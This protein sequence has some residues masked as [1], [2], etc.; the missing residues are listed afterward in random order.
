MPS[1]KTTNLATKGSEITV[2]LPVRNG[3]DYVA[4][5]IRSVLAQSFKDFELWILENGSDDGTAEV[6]RTFAD[7]RITLFELG[8]VGVQGALQ[9]AIE[10]AQTLWLA[11]M[12][13]DDLMFPHR[14]ERQIQ[15]LRRNPATVFLGTAYAFLTPFGHIVEIPAREAREV[16]KE[17]VAGRRGFPDSSLVFNRLAALDAGGVD[18]DFMKCDGLP[19]MFRLLTQGKAWAV[20][21]HLQ[22]YR[23][24]PDS[25]SKEQEHDEESRQIHFKYAPEFFEPRPEP[26]PR[27]FWKMVARLEMLSG[28]LRCVQ[29]AL[30]RMKEEGN[31][32]AEANEFPFNNAFGALGRAY[33]KWRYSGGYRRRPDWEKLFSS[34]LEQT[35]LSFDEASVRKVAARR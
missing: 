13:A 7:P 9:Y 25:L 30:D 16:T 32:E 26:V 12:D 6:I 20:A 19:L 23:L 18:K 34:L 10:N 21:D 8:P 31:F 27:S 17:E 29:R 2:I 4:N 28:D 22:L 14:L 24:R 3:R 1:R 15:F 5:A 11:R 35:C 33:Y